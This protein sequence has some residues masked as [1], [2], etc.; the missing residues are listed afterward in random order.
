M[1]SA[2][3]FNSMIWVCGGV[4]SPNGNP[5]GDL[6]ATESSNIAWKKRP[7]SEK[8][9]VVVNAIGTG[10]AACDDTLFTVV[11]NRTDGPAWKLNSKMWTIGK[12]GVTA[13]SDAW[14]ESSQQP[15]LPNDSPSTPHS[16][17]VVG[18]K[19]RLYFRRLYR[20][21]LYVEGVRPPLYVYVKP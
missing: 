12:S 4:T 6:W 7:T 17:A 20:N 18:F 14:A 13:T 11:T 15:E 9:S 21:D 2:V 3:N 1:F 16:I 19:N 10:A 8:G 5:L